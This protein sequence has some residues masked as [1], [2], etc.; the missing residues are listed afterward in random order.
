MAETLLADLKRLGLFVVECGEMESFVP[1]VG[2]HG[3]AWLAEVLRKDL[4]Q[5]PHLEHARRFVQG[6]F[7]PQPNA[8]A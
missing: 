2:G 4:R 5:D 1:T 7:S 6:L 8:K 3:N